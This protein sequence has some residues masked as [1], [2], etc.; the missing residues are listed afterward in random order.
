L[1]TVYTPRLCGGAKY[2]IAAEQIEGSSS[3]GWNRSSAEP[4]LTSMFDLVVHLK[5][6]IGREGS[7]TDR[8]K[9]WSDKMFGLHTDVP[10]VV[11]LIN[12]LHR[13][14]TK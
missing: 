2:L 8:G 10:T 1:K 12:F 4:P 5:E 14:V 6:R 13:P 7:T 11:L 9:D 3:V